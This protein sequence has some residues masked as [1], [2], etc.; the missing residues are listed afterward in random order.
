MSTSGSQLPPK[1]NNQNRQKRQRRESDGTFNIDM[2]GND[3]DIEDCIEM[4]YI[5]FGNEDS[6]DSD[7]DSDT[8]YEA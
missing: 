3:L 7:A 2:M 5:Y 4:D 1:S 6:S 8:D